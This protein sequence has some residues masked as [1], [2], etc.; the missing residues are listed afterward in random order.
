MT[1]PPTDWPP[2]SEFPAVTG[3]AATQQDVSAGSAV[4]VLQD[5]GQAIGEPISTQLPQYAFHLDEDGTRTPCILIQAEHARGQ[6]LGGAVML[7]DR[8]IM[9]GMFGE[10]ELLGT[11]PPKQP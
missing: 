11:T 9:A 10:F 5:S 6:R 7:P 1:T 2:L 8:G 3:R 4:F